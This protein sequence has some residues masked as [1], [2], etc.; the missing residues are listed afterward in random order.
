MV[1]L[2][3]CRTQCVFFSYRRCPGPNAQDLTTYTLCTVVLLHQPRPSSALRLLQY[4]L[5]CFPALTASFRWLDGLRINVR[6]RAERVAVA[7]FFCI[8]A[9][10]GEPT[11]WRSFGT[12][13]FI[14]KC[15]KRV[16]LTSMGRYQKP[17]LKV[18]LLHLSAGSL[19]SV[20]ASR[21]LLF[22]DIATT[23]AR[24]PSPPDIDHLWKNIEGVQLT[25]YA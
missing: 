25:K 15:Q 5:L 20:S 9:T 2:D 18:R 19:L 24:F 14:R 7:V 16:S 8:A 22:R 6:N 21:R 4:P 17:V 23:L 13:N 1:V 10:S 3:C 12:T 11:V